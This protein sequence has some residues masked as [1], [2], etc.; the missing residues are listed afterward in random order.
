M[1]EMHRQLRV[2]AADKDDARD[3]GQHLPDD[4][5]D[6]GPAHT[7][8]REAVAAENEDGVEHDI[9]GGPDDLRDHRE[10]CFAGGL[11]HLFSHDRVEHAHAVNRN[12][13]Q[14]FLAEADS[15]RVI[16]DSPHVRAGEEQTKHQKD[17]A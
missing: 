2:E 14:I 16:A 8:L 4:S 12:D 11:Q 3:H 15:L 6:G 7:Q 10:R 13:R 1:A 17:Q 5:G 9:C